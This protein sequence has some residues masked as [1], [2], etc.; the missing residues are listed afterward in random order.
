[1]IGW[2]REKGIGVVGSGWDVRYCIAGVSACAD[3]SLLRCLSSAI[4]SHCDLIRITSCPDVDMQKAWT[5][6]SV[7]ARRT[8]EKIPV[9]QE[10][11]RINASKKNVCRPTHF[12]RDRASAVRSAWQSYTFICT[13]QT[14][15]FT[16]RSNFYF[17]GRPIIDFGS[18]LFF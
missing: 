18:R 6:V 3:F 17:Y 14:N 13:W 1:M 4:M 7:A 2:L 9:R 11:A 5:S 10:S 15:F 16:Y 8:E 12:A